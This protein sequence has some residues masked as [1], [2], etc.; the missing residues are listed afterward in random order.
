MSKSPSSPASRGGFPLSANRDRR[1]NYLVHT[2]EGG[3]YMGGIAFVAEDMVLPN[4]VNSF[5]GPEWLIAL[6]PLLKIAGIMAPQLV[7]AHWIEP[8]SDGVAR[9]LGEWLA[10]HSGRALAG[11]RLRSG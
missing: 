9:A 7:A 1:H 10:E 6:T 11:C 3:L 5:G 2:L 4:M 8:L